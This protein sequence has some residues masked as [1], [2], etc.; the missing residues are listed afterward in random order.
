YYRGH[1][2]TPPAKIARS[3]RKAIEKERFETVARVSDRF[4]IGIHNAF[5]KLF[6]SF[7]MRKLRSY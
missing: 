2:T 7:A 5:P 6:R 3:I 4:Y 1:A